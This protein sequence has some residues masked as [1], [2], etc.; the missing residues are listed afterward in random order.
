MT[1][2][3]VLLCPSICPSVHLDRTGP[4]W[5]NKQANNQCTNKQI[6]VCVAPWDF[7]RCCLCIFLSTFWM[8]CSD[9]ESEADYCSCCGKLCDDGRLGV[10]VSDAQLTKM[11]NDVKLLRKHAQDSH[12]DWLA[13]AEGKEWLDHQN[14]KISNMKKSLLQRAVEED[15]R[16]EARQGRSPSPVVDHAWVRAFK[17]RRLAV[18]DEAARNT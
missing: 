18:Q 5:M 2:V 14:N 15:A 16:R 6:I 7:S 4:D 8:A 17:A 10:T 9:S 12:P 3:H 11:L 13:T 1:F